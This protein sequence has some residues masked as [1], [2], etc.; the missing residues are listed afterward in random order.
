MKTQALYFSA[1]DRAARTVGE[2]ALSRR[3]KVS[4]AT[5][6]AWLTRARPIPQGVFLTAVDLLQER[7]LKAAADNSVGAKAAAR[8]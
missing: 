8:R 3:L 4:A 6:S 2:E 5:L 1:L 7:E